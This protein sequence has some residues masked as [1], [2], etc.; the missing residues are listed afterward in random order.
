MSCSA[1][2]KTSYIPTCTD[3]L[4]IGTIT[5]HNTAVWIY[6]T[7]ITTGRKARFAGQ[8][9]NTGVVTLDMSLD[10]TFYQ[11]GHAYELKITLQSATDLSDT[12]DITV[13]GT[14]Y[15]CLQLSFVEVGND[16]YGWYGYDT[17]TIS[18]AD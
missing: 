10:P 2:T 6:I 16:V 11:E 9:N 5:D 18:I 14:A 3:T 4:T 15:E 13:N 12:K 1:C 8:S 17:I 7:D